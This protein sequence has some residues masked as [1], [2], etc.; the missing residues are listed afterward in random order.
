MKVIVAE[1]A[2][3]CFGVQ[4]ALQ[5][6]MK[7][8]DEH[9]PLYTLGPLIHNPQVV[10]KLQCAGI[11]VVHD[12]NEVKEGWIVMPSHG[13]PKEVKKAAEQ[14]GLRIVDVTCPFVAKVQKRAAELAAMGFQVVVVGDPGHSEV[15]GILSAAGDNA[16]TISSA[17]EVDNRDWPERVGVVA[18]TTQVGEFLNRVVNR[19]K[20]KG[21]EVE[22][23]DTICY[24]TR[25][26][27]KAVLELAPKVEALVVVG[28]RNSANTTRLREIC[29]ATGLPTCHVE[30]ADEI[31]A[32]WFEGKSVVGLTA[33]AST[34]DWIIDEV[35]Q[36]LEALP[37]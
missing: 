30:T 24:A 32:G 31:D 4:R 35:R 29:E 2:G 22:S 12:V 3:F 34:P 18:Q 28:G 16:V 25:D 23:F 10:E 17:E 36:R 33:G 21:C 1:H 6:V 37:D 13:V 14:A 7:A 26:R 9:T 11:E 5:M 15:K 8:S 20:E 27:Q 19:I